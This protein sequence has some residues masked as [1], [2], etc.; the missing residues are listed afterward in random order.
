MCYW[1]VDNSSIKKVDRSARFPR[2]FFFYA[3]AKSTASTE[4]CRY[5]PS[6]AH[7]DRFRI[8]LSLSLFL[9]S[10]NFNTLPLLHG[11]AWRFARRQRPDAALLPS[12]RVPSRGCV[13]APKSTSLLFVRWACARAIRR[14]FRI[15]LSRRWSKSRFRRTMHANARCKWSMHASAATTWCQRTYLHRYPWKAF[16]PGRPVPRRWDELCPPLTG[17]NYRSCSAII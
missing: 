7:N 12:H 6:R 1:S 11:F 10:H 16:R 13:Y 3:N 8:C 4:E 5:L 2:Y 17:L 15:V 9:V 14:F